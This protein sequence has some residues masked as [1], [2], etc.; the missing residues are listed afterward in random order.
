MFDLEWAK[1]EV[2]RG[3]ALVSPTAPSLLEHDAVSRTLH[4]VWREHC[5]ECATPEC[6]ASCPLFVGRADGGCARFSYGIY[7]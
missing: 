5:I 2:W 4:L 6:Y 3:Q 1:P 7:P